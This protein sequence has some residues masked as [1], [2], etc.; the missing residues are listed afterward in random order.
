MY[1]LSPE[2][3]RNADVE[4]Q[5]PSQDRSQNDPHPEVEF[6]FCR[7]R[8]LTDSDAEGTSHK[9]TRVLKE[10][11]CCS[12]RTSSG[13]QKKERSKSQPKC[14][15]EITPAAIEADQLLLALQKLGNNNN[16]ANFNNNFNRISQLPESLTTTMPIFD[17]K[18]EKN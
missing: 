10:V 5:E 15:S 3:L 8:N 1:G 14:R 16:Y 2:P 9:V 13:K 12:P 7:A 17:G 6:S 18:T 11:P 4:N